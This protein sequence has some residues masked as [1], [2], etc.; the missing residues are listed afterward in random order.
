[1]AALVDDDEAARYEPP[2]LERR[3]VVASSRSSQEFGWR[4][5]GERYLAAL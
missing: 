5:E 3:D 1:L 2:K 4:L